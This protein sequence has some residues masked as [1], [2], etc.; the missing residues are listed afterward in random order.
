MQAGEPSRGA[1]N[2]ARRT[3]L[4]GL[5][6]ALAIGLAAISL[7]GAE[8]TGSLSAPEALAK[9]RAGRILL[10]DVRTP[11]EWRATGVPEGARTINL[12][13][14]GGARGFVRD[15][16]EAAGGDKSRPIA[17]ICAR[18]VRSARGKRLLDA[19][20]FSHV[21]DVPEG[22]LGRGRRPGWLARKLPTR[23][24]AAC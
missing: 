11:R 15:V 1:P 6:A 17:L 2:P 3:A 9:A 13:R 12:H 22:M 10:I 4:R 19:S 24:C 14:P 20:G 8:G 7:S 5:V 18:G 21:T 16:L 23:P